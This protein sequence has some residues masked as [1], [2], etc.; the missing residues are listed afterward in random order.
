MNFKFYNGGVKKKIRGVIEV[1]VVVD[2]LVF[3]FVLLL[4]YK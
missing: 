4:L 1:L 2:V 3:N